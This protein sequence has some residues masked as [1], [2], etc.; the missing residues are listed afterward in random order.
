[1]WKGEEKR[2]GWSAFA[3]VNLKMK[4]QNLFAPRNLEKG[5]KLD[6]IFFEC[7]EVNELESIEIIE[8]LGPPF[9]EHK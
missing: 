6:V 2:G 4:R 3:D 1:M 9:I 8:S 5:F 7:P